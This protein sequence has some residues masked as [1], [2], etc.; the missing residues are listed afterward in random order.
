MCMSTVDPDRM[1]DHVCFY[2]QWWLEHVVAAGHTCVGGIWLAG[3]SKA[4]REVI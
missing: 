2:F 4:H 1:M 3:Q